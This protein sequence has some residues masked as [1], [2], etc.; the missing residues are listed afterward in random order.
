MNVATADP[1]PLPKTAGRILILVTTTRHTAGSS[2][3]A[4]LAEAARRS[5]PELLLSAWTLFVW[6]GRLRN[7]ADDDTLSGWA[8]V[9]RAGLAAL[10]VVLALA[11]VTAVFLRRPALR[12]AAFALAAFGIAVWVVRGIDIALGDHSAAFITVHMAL[13]VVTIALGVV[14]GRRWLTFASADAGG[15]SVSKSR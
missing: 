14:V 8:L 3:E 6:G 5:V 15:R 11:V 7:I 1:V 9:W 2:G 10:F 4:T 12:S 13:A